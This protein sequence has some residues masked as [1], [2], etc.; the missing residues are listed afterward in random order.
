MQGQSNKDDRRLMVA[1][2]DPSITEFFSPAPSVVTRRSVSVHILPDP[3]TGD[4]RPYFV[5]EATEPAVLCELQALPPDREP[6]GAFL[7][8]SDPN[9]SDNNQSRTTT[10]NYVVGGNGNLHVVTPVDPLFWCLRDEDLSPG[11]QAQWQP[12]NQILSIFPSMVQATLDVQQL[13]H[14][15]SK[16][17]LGDDDEESFYKFSVP[18][19]LQWLQKKQER[20]EKALTQQELLTNQVRPDSQS[21]GSGGAFVHGFN[22]GGSQPEKEESAADNDRKAARAE[23]R[24]QQAS[25]RAKVESIQVV[26]NY[27][28]RAWREAFLEHLN[29]RAQDALESPAHRSKR[30]REEKEIGQE[31]DDNNGT[32]ND[33]NMLVSTKKKKAIPRPIT[34]GAKRLAKVNTK[35]MSK[36]SSFFSISKKT[37][38]KK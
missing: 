9:V 29:V 36:M 10:N 22:L 38:K 30:K 31:N 2:V 8:A 37:T 14:V 13:G 18:K 26:C 16:M 11:K 4:N 32:N 35:G 34:V 6:Y 1:V 5:M 19:A 28:T 12:M 20:A 27:L 23:Q 7:I 21:T 17:S 15:Y 3:S 25:Q 24:R 33:E